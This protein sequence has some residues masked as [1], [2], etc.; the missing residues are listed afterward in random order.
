MASTELAPTMVDS[1]EPH[2]TQECLFPGALLMQP[3]LLLF[4]YCDQIPDK[5]QLEEGLIMT[6]DMR[7]QFIMVGSLGSKRS[8]RLW[9]Q[10]HEAAY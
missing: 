6:Q 8:W 10:K 7:V 2:D 1:E 4:F 3:D 5:R 9:Q